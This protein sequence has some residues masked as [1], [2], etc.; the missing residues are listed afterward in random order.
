LVIAKLDAPD[1]E[2]FRKVN[3]PARSIGFQLVLENLRRLREEYRGR[4]AIQV[5][6][7]QENRNHASQIAQVI[8]SLRPDEVQLNTPLRPS[9]TAPLPPEEMGRIKEAF[10]GLA[11]VSVYEAKKV[12]VHTLDAG[13]TAARRPESGTPSGGLL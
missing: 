12:A 8:R 10:V 11:F 13:D 7:C 4:L 3:R 5:M 6:L 9:A 1:E 2:L